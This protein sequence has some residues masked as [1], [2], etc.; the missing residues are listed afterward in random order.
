MSA[1]SRGFPLAGQELMDLLIGHRGQAAQHVG[2]IFL[3]VN[4][5]A[6]ATLDDGVDHRTAPPGVGMADEEPA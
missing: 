3:G 2:Q 5:P 1:V 6:T 4:T